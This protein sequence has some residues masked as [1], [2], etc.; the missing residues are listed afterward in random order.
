MSTGIV[1]HVIEI[2]DINDSLVTILDAAFDVSYDQRLNTSG[3]FKFSLSVSDVKA[4]AANLACG[5]NYIKYYRG[6]QLRWSG[7]IIRRETVLQPEESGG[8]TEV[9][10]IT[11]VDWLWLLKD[12]Y[13]SASDVHS[14]QNE[15]EIIQD[16]INDTQALSDGDLGIT[17]GANSS[18][19]N[20]TRTYEDKNVRDA[21]E[22][23]SS[24]IDGIDFEITPDRVLNIYDKKMTDRSNSHV[25]SYGDDAVGTANILTVKEVLD[26]SEI[27]NDVKG[28][29]KDT[30]STTRSSAASQ[31]A[32]G[33]RSGIYSYQ[34]ISE[35][36]TLEGHLD[37]I[38]RTNGAPTRQ[39]SVTLAPGKEPLFGTYEIGDVVTIRVNKGVVDIDQPVRIYGWDVTIDNDG[40]EYIKLLIN[41]VS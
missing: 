12:R 23:M 41:P 20:R 24:V 40:V 21:M 30:L 3:Q 10:N 1:E 11:C 32:Y 35:L 33:L 34:D 4:T 28:Y 22:Q 5:Q 26:A 17:I 7:K 6:S 39:L 25:F 16:L 38:I 13:T 14:N 27:R 8:I 37:D 2:Y 15:G 31:A 9:I 36:A 18:T 19:A 29:G